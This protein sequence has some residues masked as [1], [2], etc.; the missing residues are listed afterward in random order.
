MPLL[1]VG[2]VRGDQR[3]QPCQSARFD[4]HRMLLRH[5][6]GYRPLASAFGPR[7]FDGNVVA[8]VGIAGLELDGL[9]SPQAEG[10]LQAQAHADVGIDDF[11]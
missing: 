2:L 6:D 3:A 1:D 4:Q 9:L 7:S 8:T 5:R 10:R 11:V